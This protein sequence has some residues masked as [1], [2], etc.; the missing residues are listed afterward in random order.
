MKKLIRL[1]KYVWPLNRLF[2]GI[3]YSLSED[4]FIKT[5]CIPRRIETYVGKYLKVLQIESDKILFEEVRPVADKDHNNDWIEGIDFPFFATKNFN[6]FADIQPG[7]IGKIVEDKGKIRFV[8][9]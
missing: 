4:Y 9:G 5:S 6:S 8:A 7:F 3:L 1:K 2:Y